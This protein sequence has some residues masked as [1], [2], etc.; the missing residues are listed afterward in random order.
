ME[1]SEAASKNIRKI[2]NDIERSI[3]TKFDVLKKD[4][5]ELKKRELEQQIDFSIQSSI[6]LSSFDEVNR[7]SQSFNNR[8]APL[9][10]SIEQEDFDVSKLEKEN[11]EFRKQVND[12]DNE[13]RDL[14]EKKQDVE[15]KYKLL[16]LKS[17]K[18]REKMRN[19]KDVHQTLNEGYKKFLGLEISKLKE[20]TIK[21]SYEN[22]G[23]ECYIVL[24]F[25]TEEC[26]TETLPELNV[27]KLNYLFKEKKNFYEFVKCVREQLKQ[28]I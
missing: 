27:E 15:E 4:V 12:L 5:A 21:I 22:L 20:N 8:R 16:L 26:V 23:S 7:E 24:D 2:L 19:K 28:K 6:L 3:Q 1:Q 17:Q 18:L 9:K 25:S 14:K 10:E 11:E 13:N